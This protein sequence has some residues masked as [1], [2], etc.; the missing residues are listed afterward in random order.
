[1]EMGTF[2]V[3]Q[4]TRNVPISSHFLPRQKTGAY[5]QHFVM[6]LTQAAM[7]RTLQNFR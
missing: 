4:E 7:A 3:S 5:P 1:M 2:P 6:P